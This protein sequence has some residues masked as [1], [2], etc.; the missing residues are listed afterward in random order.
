MA[1]PTINEKKISAP[2]SAREPPMIYWLEFET[3]EKD[4]CLITNDIGMVKKTYR[5]N[6]DQINTWLCRRC[7]MG[8]EYDYA[9]CFVI[10]R[11]QL[12]ADAGADADADAG[13]RANA[14]IDKPMA[15]R[16]AEA[17]KKTGKK[18]KA[19]AK[20]SMAF[21]VVDFGCPI[22]KT[23]QKI[24]FVQDADR[25]RDFIGA[26]STFD[27]E[28]KELTGRLKTQIQKIEQSSQ[29]ESLSQYRQFHNDFI[30]GKYDLPEQRF[31]GITPPLNQLIA[32]SSHELLSTASGLT[33]M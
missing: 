26:R 24:V 31:I 2:A 25:L 23:A 29:P 30:D 8:V 9:D 16:A 21:L 1:T 5:E 6:K 3:D 32:K 28:Y 10:S 27:S 20:L 11:D 15:K 4:Y 7:E 14:K 13:A 33:N 18:T 19:S 22:E 17:G 12:D